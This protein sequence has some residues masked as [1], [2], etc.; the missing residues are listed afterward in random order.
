[1]TIDGLHIRQVNTIDKSTKHK[2][3][4]R[5]TTISKK[6]TLKLYNDLTALPYIESVDIEIFP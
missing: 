1:M 2:L 4:L 6:P 5:L 3:S